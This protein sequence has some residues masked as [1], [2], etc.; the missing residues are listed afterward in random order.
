MLCIQNYGRWPWLLIG[1]VRGQT[2][3][4]VASTMLPRRGA[5]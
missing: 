1:E 4:E 5:S 3:S 2:A